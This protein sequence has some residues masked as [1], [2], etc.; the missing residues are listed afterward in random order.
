MKFTPITREEQMKAKGNLWP[1]GWYPASIGD[2]DDSAI[3]GVSQ[4]SGAP[5]FKLNIEVFADNGSFRRVSCFLMVE[6]KMNWLLRSAAESCGLLDKYEAGELCAEDFKG[7]SCFV[8]L[9]VEKD[10]TGQYPDKNKIT[11]FKV[12][13]SLDKGAIAPSKKTVPLEDD[14]VPF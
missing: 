10:K 5:Y 4:K 12:D 2:L 6:G 8:K 11:D 13:D 1:N 7:R 9:G 3:E 14:S